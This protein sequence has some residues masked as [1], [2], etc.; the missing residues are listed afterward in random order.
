LTQSG[1]C[2][3]GGPLVAAVVVNWNNQDMTVELL[4]SL[5]RQRYEPI[6]PIVIDNASKDQG[7][8]LR[9]L[10]TD[11]PIVKAI[12]NSTNTGYAAACNQGMAI[13]LELGADYVFLLNNDV[14]VDPHAIAELV[15]VLID[16]P[17][18]GAAGPIIYHA[19]EPD[20]ISFSGGRLQLGLKPVV[21][22]DVQLRVILGDGVAHPTAWLTCAAM[23]VSRACIMRVG[24]LKT[25]YFLYWEDVDWSCMA[26]R[27]GYT[28]LVAPR[29][30]VWHRISASTSIRP[31]EALYYSERNLL[32]F[33]ERW[34]TW[35]LRCWNW[36]KVV[37]RLAASI[38]R[39]P[40]TGEREVRLLAYRDF[41][42]HRLGARPGFFV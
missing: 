16:H 9:R 23:L 34:G 13:A 19:S 37:C 6:L 30:R 38:I 1:R 10:A 29:A 41:L 11:F 31:I 40:A 27:L 17:E 12:G 7:E 25:D 28:L 15:R 24:M 4:E 18:A 35:R 14:V 33:L 42:F 20:R 8:L 5:R 2:K 3:S 39:P 36:A 21:R 32:V 22:H 26:R